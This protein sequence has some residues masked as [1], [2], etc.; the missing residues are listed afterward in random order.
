MKFV[1][2]EISKRLHDHANGIMGRY[3]TLVGISEEAVQ[4]TRAFFDIYNLEGNRL[5]GSSNGDHVLKNI[6]KGETS[7]IFTKAVEFRPFQDAELITMIQSLVA[8]DIAN[9]EFKYTSRGDHFAFSK[10]SDS[11]KAADNIR[12]AHDKYAYF[13]KMLATIEK[14]IESHGEC[15]QQWSGLVDVGKVANNIKILDEVVQNLAMEPDGSDTIKTSGLTLDDLGMQVTLEPNVAKETGIKNTK[16][17][18]HCHLPGNAA[19]EYIQSCGLHKYAQEA[20]V[21]AQLIEY[22]ESVRSIDAP[23]YGTF[24][25]VLAPDGLGLRLSFHK[26]HHAYLLREGQGGIPGVDVSASMYKELGGTEALIKHLQEQG[27][28]TELIKRENDFRRGRTNNLRWAEAKSLVELENALD[29]YAD[30]KAKDSVLRVHIIKH[31]L[32]SVSE[33]FGDFSL[34][35]VDSESGEPVT[36][37]VL[38]SP[39]MAGKSTSLKALGL[40]LQGALMG[41]TVAAESAELT[42]PDQVYH[43]FNVEDDLTHQRSTFK[44]Q[45]ENIKDFLDNAT[46]D[47]LGLFDELFNGT[48]SDYQLALAW[49]FLEKCSERSLRVM[50]STHNRDLE[51]YSDPMGYEHIKGS[52]GRPNDAINPKGGRNAKTVSIGHDHK[53]KYGSERDSEA[54]VIASEVLSPKHDDI[55]QRADAILTHIRSDRD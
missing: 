14:I 19:A 26:F 22:A 20:L 42:V 30:T 55:L 11:E 25:K 32:N 31:F 51:Y 43:N 54:L 39:N 45:L 6:F 5:S 40:I 16:I 52:H 8:S 17:K 44:A 24:P 35:E 13:L 47:S 7:K 2:T 28:V 33:N 48:S 36:V 12:I 23:F 27:L 21:V 37:V 34:G 3:C 1:D 10:P 15:F 18:T 49:A 53:F 50:I 38:P 46:I 9:A 4:S 41:R 29:A